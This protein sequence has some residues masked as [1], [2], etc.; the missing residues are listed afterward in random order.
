MG[1]LVH[2]YNVNCS[3]PTVCADG[4]VIHFCVDSISGGV[5]MLDFAVRVAL[6]IISV[7]VGL[8]IFASIQRLAVLN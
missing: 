2:V 8:T 4:E 7:V 5:E 3:H 6:I 1:I